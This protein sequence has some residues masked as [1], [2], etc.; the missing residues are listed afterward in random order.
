M[1]YIL[2]FLLQSR[3]VLLFREI[4]DRLTIR[5]INI[6]KYLANTGPEPIFLYINSPG[7]NVDNAKAIMDEIIEIQ[8]IGIEVWTIVQGLACSAA[9]DIL[10]LGTHSRRYAS[11][12]STIMLHPMSYDLPPD[13]QAFQ[14]QTSKFYAKDADTINSLIA[15]A[16][17]KTTPKKI[18]T[19]KQDIDK[20][21]WLNANEA[22]NYGVVDNIWTYQVEREI[23]EI[24]GEQEEDQ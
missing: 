2:D 18:Q 19:F 9:A 7:G 4:D 16:C 3:R 12:H 5:I 15:K 22:I 10:S 20:S 13:Y 8:D 11:K 21:L 6:L 14:E 17:G 23:N 1:K 24:V